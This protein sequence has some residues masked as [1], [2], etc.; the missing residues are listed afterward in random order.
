[1]STLVWDY[2]ILSHL[3][4]KGHYYILCG[5]V[6]Y[7]RQALVHASQLQGVLAGEK[8]SSECLSPSN[9]WGLQNAYTSA[10]S[11]GPGACCL[12]WV[13]KARC[14]RC[15]WCVQVYVY[16]PLAN[17]SLISCGHRAGLSQL[18]ILSFQ[19]HCASVQ[20]PHRWPCVFLH[21]PL[22]GMC[23]YTVCW[24]NLVHPLLIRWLDT[25]V[26][27]KD[28]NSASRQKSCCWTNGKKI[29]I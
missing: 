10:S 27:N 22:L 12:G 4:V 29:A 8:G 20:V 26:L 5:C 1:M 18:C 15:P 21:T 14:W 23:A 3:L 2:C 13:P 25:A 7:A 28:I 24:L 17:F 9:W 6:V 11:C 19:E 16:V